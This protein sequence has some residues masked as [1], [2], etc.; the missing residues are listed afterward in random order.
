M[1]IVKGFRKFLILLFIIYLTLASTPIVEAG[2]MRFFPTLCLLIIAF[3]GFCSFATGETARMGKIVAF[4]AVYIAFCAVLYPS[5][6]GSKLMTFLKSTYWCWVYFIAYTIFSYRGID[7]EHFDNAIMMITILFALSFNYS[8]ISRIVGFDLIGDNA[9]FYPLL[10]IPWITCVSNTAKRWIMVVIIA[11]CAITALKRSG[12]IILSIS[13]LL[14]YYNDFM[15]KKRL[16]A[17]TVIA[18]FLIL[19]GVLVIYY[20]KSDSISDINQRFSMLEED[21][22]SGRED[23]Y[24]DVINRYASANFVQQIFGQ[25]F[26]SVRGEGEDTTMALS[27]HNDFL[28]V[29]YDFGLVGLFFYVLIHLSLIKWIICLFRSGSPLAFPVL[30]S[31][32]CFFVMSMVSHLI[33]YPTYFGLLTAF[34]AYAECKDRKLRCQ[35]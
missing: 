30:I 27:A 17:K 24:K 20:S 25:G 6:E 32:V 34:W 35:C 8:H 11:L 10:M 28:E 29:M 15:Y 14:L 22:G 31:Y 16:K 5:M 1:K 33:L 23:I 26:N 21:G 19:I 13:V 18:A 9:V 7:E 3:C 2:V 12:I 4:F